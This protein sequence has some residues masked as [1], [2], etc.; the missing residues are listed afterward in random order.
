MRRDLGF[1]SHRYMAEPQTVR[2]SNI[3][4]GVSLY[5]G[6][7]AEHDCMQRYAM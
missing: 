5:E 2:A 6:L 1:Y 7:A 4:D 3:H